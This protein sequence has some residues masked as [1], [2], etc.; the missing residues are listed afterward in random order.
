MGEQQ[1]GI[2]KT[3]RGEGVLCEFKAFFSNRTLAGISNSDL[4]DVPS[5]GQ[6]REERLPRASIHITCGFTISFF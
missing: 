4:E 6:G 2:I 5:P 1:G 3:N